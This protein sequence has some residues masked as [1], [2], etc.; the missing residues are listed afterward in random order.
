MIYCRSVCLSN[1]R[2]EVHLLDVIILNLMKMHGKYS[3]KFLKKLL[4]P[5][6]KITRR[7]ATPH[8]QVNTS[9]GVLGCQF[10]RLSY[11]A[12]MVNEWYKITEHMRNNID[13]VKPKKE[14]KSLSHCYFVHHKSHTDWRENESDPRGKTMVTDRISLGTATSKLV[15]SSSKYHPPLISILI[16]SPYRR[17]FWQSRFLTSYLASKHSYTFL[18]PYLLGH[19]YY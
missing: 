6:T 10:R 12:P 2:I 3:I 1:K 9:S 14:K 7:Y 4:M 18:N 15:R 19:I 8:Q 17:F 5:E 13:E 16:L 11:V